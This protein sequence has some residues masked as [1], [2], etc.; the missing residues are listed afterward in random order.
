MY[1]F[2][3]VPIGIDIALK[4]RPYVT[5]FLCAISVICFLIYKYK[6]YG[7]WWDLNLLV[8]QPQYP[9]L[10]TAITH[11]FL[12]GGYFHII[13]NFVYLLVFGRA[14]EDRLGSFRYY[15]VFIVSAVAGVYIHTALTAIYSPEYLPYGIIGASGATSGILGAYLVRLSFSRVRVA[16]WIFMPLQ[17]VNRAGRTYLPIA[18]AVLFWFALQGVRTVM[19]YGMGGMQVAYGVHLGGFAAGIALAFVF[20]AHH[21]GRAERHLARARRF[22]EKA[23]WFGA[24][25]EY[26]DYLALVPGDA[27]AHAEFARSLIASGDK[28][29]A[30]ESYESAVRLS[31]EVGARDRAEGLFAEA[32]RHN[33]GF[34]LPEPLHIDLACGMERTLQFR[35][36]LAAYE[37]FVWQYPLSMEAPFVLLR[38]A[39]I[40]ERRLCKPQEAYSCYRRLARE[41]AADRWAEL[42]R[43]EIARLE[44]LDP[45]ISTDVRK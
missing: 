40:F 44:R 4:R 10:A 42:A 38:M 45:A 39:G 35:S 25:A 12:H 31:L 30:R 28:I 27:E 32:L 11:P 22:F 37:H 18:C 26:A 16:Y 33:P 9:T 3:Y 2:Y 43:A 19:Q 23:D 36:A 24:R 5:Y 6:P 1:F 7:P 20:K 15:L 34:A 41:Y 17:G 21:A 13:G 14:L 29:G 8:F